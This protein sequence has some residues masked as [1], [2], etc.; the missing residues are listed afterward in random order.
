[1]SNNMNIIWKTDLPPNEWDTL[2]AEMGGHPLQSA[3]WGNAKKAIEGIEDQRWAAYQ[4]GKPIGLIRF[5]LRGIGPLKKIAW[6]PQ[7]PTSKYWQD[8]EE[9]FLNQLKKLGFQLC[10]TMPWERI[11]P[12]DASRH[13]IWIDLSVGKE[14][15]WK[16]LDKQW[17]YGVRTAQKRDV[18]ITCTPLENDLSD[19]FKLCQQISHTKKF[20]LKGSVDFLRYLLQHPTSNHAEALLFIAKVKEKV[21]AGAC[22]L[23]SGNNLHYM[24]GGVDRNY[25]KD[26]VGELLHWAVIERACDHGYALYDLEGIHKTNR[27]DGVAAFKKKMGG[28]II[29]LT[30]KQFFPLSYSGKLLARFLR[31]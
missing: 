5:E 14:T 6:V 28:T 12:D 11:D 8:I 2:L 4:S 24:W 27:P 20:S 17:R 1:M 30:G 25:P 18:Q 23:R 22:I 9:A 29:G 21:C 15:L 16:N 26:R 3:L 10:V 13:T 31:D 7:G 19:F